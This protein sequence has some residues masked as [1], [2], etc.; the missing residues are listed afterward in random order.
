V[1]SECTVLIVA[2]IQLKQGIRNH[3]D[4]KS[5]SIMFLL[6]KIMCQI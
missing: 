1:S 4:C 5:V 6:Q 3:F 2:N